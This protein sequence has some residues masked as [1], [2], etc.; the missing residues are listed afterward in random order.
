MLVRAI[1]ERPL[2]TNGGQT[3]RDARYLVVINLIFYA[4]KF[5]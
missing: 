5:K 4:K 3:A 2:I 1:T